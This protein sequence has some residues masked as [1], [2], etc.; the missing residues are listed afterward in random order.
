MHNVPLGVTVTIVLF[1]NLMLLG[2]GFAQGS[3]LDV[4][5]VPTEMTVVNATGSPG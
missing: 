4:P 3:K 1:L 2:V 5:Y